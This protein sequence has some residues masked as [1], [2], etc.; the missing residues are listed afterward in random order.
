MNDFSPLIKLQNL[1]KLDCR[2]TTETTSLLHLAGCCKLQKLLC[3]VNAKDLIE[4]KER[5]PEIYIVA[6]S[7]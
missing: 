1:E 7:F 6:F 3:P 2:K 5:R 4:L